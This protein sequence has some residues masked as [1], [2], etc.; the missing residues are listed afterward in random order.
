MSSPP[1]THREYAYFFVSGHGNPEVITERLGL[2]P[3]DSWSAGDIGPR[4]RV[5]QSMSWRLDSGFDDTEPLD[6]H[7]DALLQILG[8][9]AESLRQLWVEYD[10]TLQCV[11]YFPASGHGLHLNRDAIRKAAQLGLAFDL[12]FYG[13]DEHDHD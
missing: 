11:G 1:L 10:L 8:T 6:R 12:D 4:G 5:R 9:K 3:S 13:I 2:R 7:I